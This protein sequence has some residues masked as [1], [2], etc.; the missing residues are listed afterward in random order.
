MMLQK[1]GSLWLSLP[2][3]L[4]MINSWWP[5]PN[6]DMYSSRMRFF[7]FEPETEVDRPDIGMG[8]EGVHDWGGAEGSAAFL[9]D[10]AIKAAGVEEGRASLGC[11][12][13]CFVWGLF[14]MTKELRSLLL[15]PC[16][17]NVPIGKAGRTT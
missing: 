12:I 9:F 1:E 13:D 8:R 6:L 14:L 2:F 10:A 5:E 4:V 16:S 11:L 7:F 15:S 17:N 3:F